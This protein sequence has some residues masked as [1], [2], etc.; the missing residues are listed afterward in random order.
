MVNRSNASATSAG[1][2]IRCPACGD[3][4][5]PGYTAWREIDLGDGLFRRSL[6]PCSDCGGSAV[7][8]GSDG[9]AGGYRDAANLGKLSSEAA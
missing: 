6:V 5:H 3:T 4:V 8:S 9:A 2:S 7:V 1:E